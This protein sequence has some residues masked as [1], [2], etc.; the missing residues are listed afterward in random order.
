[1]TFLFYLLD[2]LFLFPANI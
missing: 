2:S 1:L